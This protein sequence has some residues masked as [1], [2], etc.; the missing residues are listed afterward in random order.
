MYI[1]SQGRT[2]TLVNAA[3]RY[4]SGANGTAGHD[5]MDGAAGVTLRGGAGDDSYTLWSNT[6]RVVENAGSGVDT[7]IAQFWGAAVLGDNVENLVLASEGATAGTGNALDNIIAAGIVGADLNGMGGNDVLV[8]GRGADVFRVKAGNGSDAVVGFETGQDVIKL[9]GYGLTRFTDLI[10]RGQQEGNDVRFSFANGEQLVVQGVSLAALNAWDFGFAVGQATGLP[11]SLL[12]ADATLTF[13]DPGRAHNQHGWYVVN[14][15]WGVGAMK[16]GVDYTLEARFTRSDMTGGTTFNW[17]MPYTTALHPPILAYPEV[18]FGVSPV[19]AHANNPTDTARVFPVQLSELLS[20][21]SFHDVSYAGNTSGFNVAYDIWLTSVPN[22]DHTTLTN[23]VMVWVHKGAF[24]AFGKVVGTYTDGDLTASIYHEGTYTAVVFDVDVPQA[25][26]DITSIL[27]KLIDLGIVSSSEYLA[28]VELGAEVVSG[29]GS[30]TINNLDL[31]VKVRGSDGS[32]IVKDVTGSGTTVREEAPAANPFFSFGTEWLFG[33][34]GAIIGSK[35]TAT[36]AGGVR[37][38]ITMGGVVTS[39]QHYALEAGPIVRTGGDAADAFFVY[40]RMTAATR[41]TG[42]AGADI[43]ALQGNYTA[44]LT[45]GAQSL[46]DIETVSLL[47]GSDTRF[48]DSAG[49]RYSY[50]LT[51]VDANVAS[52]RQLIVNGAALLAGEAMSVDG[53][54]ER[55]GSFLIYGGRGT[56]LLTGGSKADVFFFAEGRLN[57]GDRVVGGDGSDI[58]VLRGDYSGA[59]RIVF[60]ADTLTGVETVTL[61]SASDT[62]FFSGGVTYRYD[63]TTNDANVA[64]GATMTLN[65]GALTAAETLRIDAGAETDGNLRLFGGAGADTLIAGAGNDLLYGGL[66]SDRLDGGAGVDLYQYKAAV[67]STGLG[68]DQIVGF[69]AGDDVIDLPVAVTNWGQRVSGGTLSAATF[70][71]DLA[72]A[73]NDA[74]D[75]NGATLFEASSGSFAGRTFVVVDADGN[76]AYDFGKDFVFEL[77]NLT[78]PIDH[79]IG[80]FV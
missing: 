17:S 4:T 1:N 35:V 59:D 22:G 43:V 16:S 25:T 29:V 39:V 56:D 50:A 58:M 7:V 66:G 31:E 21:K 41:L 68:F 77:V 47:S 79:M 6:A 52:G 78:T 72:T 42:G 34:D 76:G 51:T 62:R 23:E 18:I 19:G 5:K 44:G 71:A 40:G 37:Q 73:V 20:L 69:V 13:V 15:A 45:F 74:L 14:N 8:G 67:E 12:P 24:A 38:T 27:N 49:A 48:G 61:M 63:V 32:I 2:L 80:V 28:S 30:L 36:D 57:A 10:S 65:G 64:A 75:P 53:S 54:A 60:G 9:D 70:D 55:D 33:S 3:A 26:L 46:V 11:A